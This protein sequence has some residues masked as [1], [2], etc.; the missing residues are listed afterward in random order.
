MCSASSLLPRRPRPRQASLS[1]LLPRRDTPDDRSCSNLSRQQPLSEGP[2]DYCCVWCLGFYLQ[3]AA[4]IPACSGRGCVW[5]PRRQL[6]PPHGCHLQ[7]IA[8][9]SGVVAALLVA[10]SD[11]CIVCTPGS[12]VFVTKN[13]SST[14]SVAMSMPGWEGLCLK[15]TCVLWER[16]R[17]PSPASA[18]TI[19]VKSPTVSYRLS[20]R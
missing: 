16:V 12:F 10:I 4:S 6:Y 2:F 14:R 11:L 19:V 20:Y 13:Y 3:T 15:R 7:T 18:C 17:S 1:Q 8:F 9:R 5:P